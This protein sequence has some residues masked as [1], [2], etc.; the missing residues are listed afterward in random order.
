MTMLEVERLSSDVVLPERA[1][2]GSACM[3][4][5]FCFPDGVTK[6]TMYD[7][8]NNILLTHNPFNEIT[9]P[10]GYRA[11]I[12]TA[13]KFIIPRSHHLKVYS[14]SSMALKRGLTLVN[15]VGIIDEDFDYEL[16]V[17]I[18]NI[19][20]TDVTLR[21]HEKIAQIE[22]CANQSLPVMWDVGGKANRV[23]GYG[24]TGV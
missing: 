8:N 22:L 7:L 1:T 11:M 20:G 4:V 17:L 13:L 19:S 15:S 10:S 18:M 3:D 2:K 14:R 6:V 12:P 24:S 21:V 23:G 5:S 16:K 9:I